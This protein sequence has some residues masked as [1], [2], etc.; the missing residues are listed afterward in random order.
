MFG[1]DQ[2]LFLKCSDSYRYLPR[3]IQSKRVVWE[4]YLNYY[5]DVSRFDG[6]YKAPNVTSAHFFCRWG[7]GMGKQIS[8]S[9]DSSRG[10]LF[11]DR[12][13]TFLRY[14]GMSSDIDRKGR[15]SFWVRCPLFYFEVSDWAECWEMMAAAKGW[16][17]SYWPRSWGFEDPEYNYAFKHTVTR[18]VYYTREQRLQGKE[19]PF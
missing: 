3:I 11:T 14:F 2:Y 8:S 19:R 16:S 6:L 10:P 1:L 13:L 4:K 12:I 18:M 5:G 9:V 17:L 15:F 7:L